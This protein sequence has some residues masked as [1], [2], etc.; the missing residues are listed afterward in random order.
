MAHGYVV[1]FDFGLKHIGVAIGQTL[2]GTAR[3]V[4]TLSARQGRPNWRT[5]A[6]LLKDYALIQA[7]VGLPL[8]MD[9]TPS[10]MA[11]RAQAFARQINQHTH[12]P[13]FAHQQPQY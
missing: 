6:E 4:K 7:V 1:A 13:T 8:N 12:V 3:G 10:D 11:T 9:G 2:T 5:V